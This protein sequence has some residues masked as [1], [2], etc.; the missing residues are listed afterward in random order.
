MPSAVMKRNKTGLTH[1]IL[2][3]HHLNSVFQR[4]CSIKEGNAPIPN[5]EM[6]WNADGLGAE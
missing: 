1:F 4:V 2:K 3:Y 6:Q 5:V